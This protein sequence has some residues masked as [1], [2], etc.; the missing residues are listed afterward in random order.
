M[1]R[2]K[3]VEIAYLNQSRL[4]DIEELLFERRVVVSYES[5][6]RWCDKF[7]AGFARHVKAARRKRSTTWHPD[8]LFVTPRSEQ[9]INTV[10]NSTSSCRSVEIR[11]Q[12][13]DFSNA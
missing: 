6:R 13:S 2:R 5:I 10:R 12:R 8:E 3:L 1:Y 7:G 11:W 4:R 9:S